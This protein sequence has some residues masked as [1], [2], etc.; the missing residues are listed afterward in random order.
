MGFLPFEADS[1]VKERGL[2]SV[3]ERLGRLCAL[4]IQKEEWKTRSKWKNVSS[5]FIMTADVYDLPTPF[6][7]FF[8]P[9]HLSLFIPRLFIC[10]S[11]MTPSV[12]ILNLFV[13]CFS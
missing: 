9:Y 10:P 13:W 2:I 5:S 3:L 1:V 11:F 8:S 6:M 12:K 7:T 4:I